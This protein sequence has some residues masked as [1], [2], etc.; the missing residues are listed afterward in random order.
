MFVMAVLLGGVLSD[1]KEAEKLP[2]ELT[3]QLDYVEDLIHMAIDKAPERH[4]AR[5]LITLVS[6]GK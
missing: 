5:V 1:Y 2:G 3:A 4:D 6:S